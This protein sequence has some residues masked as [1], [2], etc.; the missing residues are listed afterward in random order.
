MTRL[1]LGLLYAGVLAAG[2]GTGLG[3][4]LSSGVVPTLA[5]AQEPSDEPREL[6]ERW[7]ADG[8]T[9]LQ[10]GDLTRAL[11][12][13]EA[14]YQARPAPAPLYNAALILVDLDQPARATNRLELYVERYPEHAARNEPGVRELLGELHAQVGR[15]R[16]DVQ[17]ADAQ[18]QIDGA[19]R[20]ADAPAVHAVLPG[21]HE[22]RFEAAGYRAERRVVQVAAG[23]DR[24]VEVRLEADPEQ[25]VNAMLTGPVES[26]ATDSDE[27]V[28]ET[29]TFWLV[30]AGVVVVSAA[31]AIGLGFALQG[32]DGVDAS[33]VVLRAPGF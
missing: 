11:R 29:P 17:P 24:P 25:A 3:E 14:S 23:Q 8:M 10:D 28:F 12:A 5:L 33:A 31:V 20:E 13:F 16:I 19:L 7:W 1:V 18:V 26:A 27:S 2:M 22:L 4:G 15:L 21:E 32:D 30:V 6:G 9:A